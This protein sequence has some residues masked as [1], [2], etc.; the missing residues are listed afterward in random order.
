[1]PV[2]KAG[3]GKKAAEKLPFWKTKSMDEMSHKEWESLCDGCGRCCLIKFEYEDT[4]EV[5][6][7]D[8][9]CRL[10]N[11]KTC[12]CGNYAERTDYVKDCL[13]LTPKILPK[14]NC[15]PPTCGYRLVQEGK[16][17]Y[18]WHPLVSGRKSTV[19]E[20]GISVRGRTISE[21]TVPEDDLE[22]HMVKWPLTTRSKSFDK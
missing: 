8:V 11:T 19:H 2:K 7:T 1:M 16:D 12:R 9:A 21:V 4:K 6:Y 14:M 17:L 18:P 20:A 3:T 15:L 10:L 22:F 13:V 5:F